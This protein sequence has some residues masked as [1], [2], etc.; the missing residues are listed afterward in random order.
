[1]KKIYAFLITAAGAAMLLPLMAA[2]C[3]GGLAVNCTTDAECTAPQTCKTI[4]DNSPCT[5]TDET[6]CS[7]A[8]GEGE[9]EG[10][11]GEGEGAGGEGEGAGADCPDLGNGDGLVVSEVDLDADAAGTVCADLGNPH[12]NDF[13]LTVFIPTAGN[14]AGWDGTVDSGN[15][16]NMSSSGDADDDDVFAEAFCNGGV[17]ACVDDTLGDCDGTADCACSCTLCLTNTPPDLAV[18]A[19][20]SAGDTS[21]GICAV[22]TG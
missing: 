20:D 4:T 5:S 15:W 17:A 6:E 22:I 2:D 12:P 11:G 21:D 7:C 3:G 18:Q 10:A 16:L 19:I 8:E 14:A 13:T 9:G 1:M